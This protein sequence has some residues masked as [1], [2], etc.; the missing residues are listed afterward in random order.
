MREPEAF[1]LPLLFLIAL[2][3]FADDGVAGANHVAARPKRRTKHVS[4]AARFR[5]SGLRFRE[6]AAPPV[7]LPEREMACWRLGRAALSP[8]WAQLSSGLTASR[9]SHAEEP[10][11]YA[12]QWPCNGEE[13]AMSNCDIGL[14]LNTCFMYSHLSEEKSLILL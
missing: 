1:L 9:P 12:R 6:S 8:E 11:S 5:E 14:Q 10:C 7:T 2:C 4:R 13:K 3:R